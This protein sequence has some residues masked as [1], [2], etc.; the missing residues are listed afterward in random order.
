MGEGSSGWEWELKM[1]RGYGEER[2][3]PNS[4]PRSW[5]LH[6]PFAR[7]STAPAGRGGAGGAAVSRGRSGPADGQE[8]SG[9][10]AGIGIWR[11][12]LKHRYRQTHVGVGVGALTVHPEGQ[13]HRRTDSQPPP[14]DSQTLRGTGTKEQLPPPLELLGCCWRALGELDGGG[15]GRSGLTGCAGPL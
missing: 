11:V 10:L 12:G 6:H 2:L 7:C 14:I 9:R 1:V 15:R 5:P 13:M 8:K 4:S 3:R